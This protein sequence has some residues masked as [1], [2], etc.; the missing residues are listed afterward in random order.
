MVDN[1]D[2]IWTILE[3]QH[4]FDVFD[5]ERQ[6]P[7]YSVIY[8]GDREIEIYFTDSRGEYFYTMSAHMKDKENGW[9]DIYVYRENGC[10]IFKDIRVNKKEIKL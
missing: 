6:F 5:D 1:E 2:V 8:E 7:N 3:F 4:A 9:L 10:Q